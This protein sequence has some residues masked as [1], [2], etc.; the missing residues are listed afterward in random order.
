MRFLLAA[1]YRGPYLGLEPL[2]R[3]L[4][5]RRCAFV[6]DGPAA[7]ERR[8]RG[9]PFLSPDAASRLLSR[10]AF[11]ALVRGVSNT[12]ARANLET[13]LAREAA[14]RGL[15]V[16]AVEDY[17]GQFPPGQPAPG[18][19]FVESDRT[20]ALYRER[21]LSSDVRA[22]GNPRYAELRPL[23]RA[24]RAEV[25]ARLGL[26][27]GPVVFWAGQ[28]DAYGSSETLEALL[29][30]LRRLGASLVYRAHPYAP[31]DK[32]EVAG[33]EAVDATGADDPVELA[34]ACDLVATQ[35]STLA[36]EASYAGVPSLFVLLPGLGRARHLR[37]TGTADPPWCRDGLAFLART[38][39][40]IGPQL[41][42]ALRDGPARRRALAG[43]RAL[44][45][46]NRSSARRIARLVEDMTADLV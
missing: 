13:R 39:A 19:L 11:S 38:R 36:V 31:G 46:A 23:P 27:A 43:F 44:R 29:P 28:P 26:G 14:R 35:F 18:V 34:S 24:R 5:S 37:S 10:G 17:P 33:L 16:F 1:V 22:T 30:H 3:A 12:P 32:P 20:R 25:R 45:R 40:E 8:K 21:G 6:L 42:R 4:G 15:P 9:R 2:A 7:A 41:A